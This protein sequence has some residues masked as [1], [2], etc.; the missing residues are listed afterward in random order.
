MKNLK[1][2]K[3]AKE[4]KG[5]CW[6][7]RVGVDYRGNMWVE[8]PFKVQGVAHKEG[9]TEQ[10]A[11]AV[12]PKQYDY[13]NGYEFLGSIGIS[14]Y[15]CNEHRTFRYTVKAHNFLSML[16]E[17]QD[18]ETYR[19]LFLKPWASKYSR[20]QTKKEMNLRADEEDRFYREIEKEEGWY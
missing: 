10:I 15:I 9:I 14:P 4:L 18:L 19:T 7:F 8:K 20:F 16:T 3:T 5:G 11:V 13:D 12:V 1:P 6:Y 17:K 2:I